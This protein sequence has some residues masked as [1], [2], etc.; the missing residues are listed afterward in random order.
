MVGWFAGAAMAADVRLIVVGD[1]GETTEVAAMV[2]ADIVRLATE[3]GPAVVRVVATGDLYYD[4][5]P[6]ELT[7]EACGEAAAARY[8]AFY[9]A[10]FPPTVLAVTGNHDL[11]PPGEAK[12]FSAEAHAC[13][14]AAFRNMGWL[15]ADEPLASRVVQVDGARVTADVALIDWRLLGSPEE[16]DAAVVPDGSLRRDATFTIGV[17]HYPL[18]GGL[19]T[20]KCKEFDWNRALP[21]TVPRVD[22]WLNGHS[23][24]LEARR[25][26]RVLDITSGAGKELDALEQCSDASSYYRFT[27][28]DPV[29]TG[30][31][32]GGYTIVDLDE[33]DGKGRI[34]VTPVA[35]T[36]G[37]GCAPIP[38]VAFTCTSRGVGTRC[39]AR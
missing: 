20:G 36:V 19:T 4:R 23:H 33:A 31:A 5:P 39:D 32:H 30:P 35:C 1:T 16:E 15:R 21:A 38:A 25:V 13:T 3:P 11:Y 2:S 7:T 8:R 26:R 10:G 34:S 6:A 28:D 17:S 12:A 37:V 9:G 22:V 27:A 29:P 14:E 18:P 24:H